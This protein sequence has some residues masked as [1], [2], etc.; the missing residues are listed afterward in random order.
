M[1]DVEVVNSPRTIS[2]SKGHSKWSAQPCSHYP[3]YTMAYQHIAIVIM[4]FKICIC[5]ILFILD[6]NISSNVSFFHRLA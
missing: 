6:E 3:L 1:P 2:L 5:F 4:N